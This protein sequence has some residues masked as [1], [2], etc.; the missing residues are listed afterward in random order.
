MTENWTTKDVS[1]WL[2]EEVGLTEYCS[3]FEENDITGKGLIKTKISINNDKELLSLNTQDL[4][5]LSIDKVGHRKR[6][7]LAIQQIKQKPQTNAPSNMQKQKRKIEET[8]V[9]ES[10][11][12]VRKRVKLD[13]PQPI[14]PTQP[15]HAPPL[16]TCMICFDEKDTIYPLRNCKSKG[17]FCLECLQQYMEDKISTK[18]IPIHVRTPKTATN[19]SSVQIHRANMKSLMIW[20]YS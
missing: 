19:S 4:K 11:P 16:S 20:K 8:I 6:I 17:S 5:D 14:R 3:V 13:A 1:K 7:E 9:Q 10:S 12:Q 2:T 15:T 18:T